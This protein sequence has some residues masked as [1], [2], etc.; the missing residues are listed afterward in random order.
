MEKPYKGVIMLSKP[1][2]DKIAA[3]VFL[4]RHQGAPLP[5]VNFWDNPRCSLEQMSHWDKKDICPIDLGDDKYHDKRNPAGSATEYIAGFFGRELSSAEVK[6]IRM[7]ADH[8]GHNDHGKGGYLKSFFM[9]IPWTLRELYE[10]DGYDHREV[11]DRAGH[12]V[13]AWLCVEDGDRGRDDGGMEK[14]FSD[15]LRLLKK[16][17]FAPFTPERYLRDL[18]MLGCPAVEIRERVYWWIAAWKEVK[19]ALKEAE[20][21]FKHM[22]NQYFEA[23]GLQGIAIKDAGKFVAKVASRHCDILLTVD[24]IGHVAIMTKKLDVSNLAR[25]IEYLEPDRWH[26][27]ESQGFVINGGVI[28]SGVSPTELSIEELISFIQMYPPRHRG[29]RKF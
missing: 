7:L 24:P 16:C 29:G 2:I 27:E 23:G 11:I 5:V 12:V 3:K 15:L 26:H 22:P 4:E 14:G 25:R 8:N 20:E 21:E 28:Y 17:N 1:P 9:A 19:A 18:W 10:L 6:L 13:D